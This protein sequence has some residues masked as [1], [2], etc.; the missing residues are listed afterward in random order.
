MNELSDGRNASPTRL[1]AILEHVRHHSRGP[2][3][4]ATKGVT[5]WD[6]C[7]YTLNKQTLNCRNIRRT[8]H[9]CPSCFN[10]MCSCTRTRGVPCCVAAA[11]GRDVI[12]SESTLPLH[13]Y[14]SSHALSSAKRFPHLSPS[15]IPP[16]RRRRATRPRQSGCCACAPP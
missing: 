6:P 10:K 9:C 12:G 16:D 15:P 1:D 7:T 2:T 4:I 13:L 5:M 3:H 11:C 8:P 14:C